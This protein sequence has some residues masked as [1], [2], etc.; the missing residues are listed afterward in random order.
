MALKL[1]QAPPRE[2]IHNQRTGEDGWFVRWLHRNEVS[3]D[4]GMHQRI[5]Q[6]PREIVIDVIRGCVLVREVW[7]TRDE[8]CIYI[9]DQE[10]S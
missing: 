6:E 5:L 7:T 4:G 2:K 10:D 1:R 3:A 8:M 9:D